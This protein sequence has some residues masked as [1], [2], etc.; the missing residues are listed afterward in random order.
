VFELQVYVQKE[1]GNS[2][3]YKPFVKKY[4]EQNKNWCSSY[5]IETLYVKLLEAQDDSSHYRLRKCM[6]P[7]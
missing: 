2:N 5:S 1:N 3:N 7:I 6:Q 4:N